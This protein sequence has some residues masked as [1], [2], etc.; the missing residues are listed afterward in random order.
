MTAAPK[1]ELLVGQLVEH[2][3]H[4]HAEAALMLLQTLLLEDPNHADYWDYQLA[5]FAMAQRFEAAEAAYLRCEQLGV[6]TPKH[7]STQPITPATG[8][9]LTACST[10]RT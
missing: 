1:A 10:M 2:L 8:G 5:A 4:H 9:A 6:A 3:N 7:L